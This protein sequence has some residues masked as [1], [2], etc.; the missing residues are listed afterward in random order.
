MLF[1][2]SFEPVFEMAS[3]KLKEVGVKT[4][5]NTVFRHISAESSDMQEKLKGMAYRGDR[6]SIWAI[7]GFHPMTSE[8]FEEIIYQ[9]SSLAMKDS[10][11]VGEIPLTIINADAGAE[12]H[13]R[14]WIEKVLKRNGFL[15]DFISYEDVAR[16][17]C[18]KL[19]INGGQHLVTVDGGE[20]RNVLFVAQQQRLSD[21][22]E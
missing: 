20:L 2:I 17:V 1:D 19:L 14:R 12:D 6:L 4:S 21:D 3:K 9:I 7:Q 18:Q 10:Q 5:R 13:A 15:V 16:D 22:Q 11:L 8:R